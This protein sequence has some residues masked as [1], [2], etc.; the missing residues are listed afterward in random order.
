[1]PDPDKAGDPGGA[2]GIGGGWFS[3]VAVGSAGGMA[4]DEPAAPQAKVLTV[5]DGVMAG[6]REDRSGQAL[7]AV[8][9]STGFEVVETTV[10]ADGIVSVAGALTRMASGFSGL[11][12]TTG[13]TGFAPR[14]QTPEGTREVIDREAPGLAEAMR[15]VNPLGRL[16]RA[17]AGIKGHAIIVNTPGSPK[18]AAECLGA[19]IDVLPHA[20]ELLADRPTKHL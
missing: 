16:S 12:V 7:V 9:E 6:T 5:S 13:G 2:A 14:D 18:G 3:P 20:L 1:M 17:I 15:L 11:V 8:L 19:I 4:E 10:V